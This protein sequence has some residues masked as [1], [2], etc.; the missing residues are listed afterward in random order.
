MLTPQSNL[1]D[2]GVSLF[3]LFKLHDLFQL[4]NK[5]S[6]SEAS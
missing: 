3:K 4:L 5:T 6:I 2:C 1:E